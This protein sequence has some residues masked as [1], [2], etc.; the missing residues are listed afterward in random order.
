MKGEKSMSE[1]KPPV[2]NLPAPPE[3]TIVYETF[4]S[5]SKEKPNPPKSND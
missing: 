2:P 5:T 3:P 1:E 4:T